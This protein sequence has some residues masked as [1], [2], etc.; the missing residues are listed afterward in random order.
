[1]V[2]SFFPSPDASRAGHLVLL[3]FVARVV[4]GLS[5]LHFCLL[6]LNLCSRD[7]FA[8]NGVP[9]QYELCFSSV[10]HSF[11]EIPSGRRF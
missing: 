11:T 7:M 6:E 5:L 1:M 3:V 8:K 4:R 9:M 2:L 10:K